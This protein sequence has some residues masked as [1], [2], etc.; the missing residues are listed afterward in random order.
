MRSSTLAQ[1]EQ[2]TSKSAPILCGPQPSERAQ[3]GGPKRVPIELQDE[4]VEKACI[5][6]A[7]GI[8]TWSEKVTAEHE[9]SWLRPEPPSPASPPE[10]AGHSSA[11]LASLA[12]LGSEL[13]FVDKKKVQEHSFI[14]FLLK[15]HPS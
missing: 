4:H 15:Q 12:L 9:R 10:E 14:N 8:S 7:L 3:I 11:I 2:H 13:Q 1:Y 6:F 5:P